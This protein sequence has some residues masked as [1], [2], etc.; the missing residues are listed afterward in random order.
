MNPFRD[1]TIERTANR[2]ISEMRDGNCRQLLAQ[3]EKDYRKKRADFLCN[4]EAQHPLISWNLVEWEDGRPR[5]SALQRPAL[6]HPQ[7][8]TRPT[9][10]FSPSPKKRK[11]PAGPLPST[12]LFTGASPVTSHLNC[13]PVRRCFLRP[14]DE[15]LRDVLGRLPISPVP[16]WPASHRKRLRLR[17]E[18]KPRF[19]APKARAVALILTVSVGGGCDGAGASGHTDDRIAAGASTSL[20]CLLSWPYIRNL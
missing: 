6:Q 12:T 4:S 15:S 8:R 13:S 19:F 9:K 3:W 2:F 18:P 7:P 20:R 17:S 16:I 1:R 10:T 5:D 14:G 11:I